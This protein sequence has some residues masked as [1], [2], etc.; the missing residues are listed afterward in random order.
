MAEM[1]PQYQLSYID[2]HEKNL[3][4][5]MICVYIFARY[6]ASDLIDWNF[7]IYPP[8]KLFTSKYNNNIWYVEK[9]CTVHNTNWWQYLFVL[10]RKCWFKMT[11]PNN[12]T[13]EKWNES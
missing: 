5:F 7:Q 3:V 12:H 1:S 9:D 2:L 10:F 11:E 6:T 4:S 8:V 13:P